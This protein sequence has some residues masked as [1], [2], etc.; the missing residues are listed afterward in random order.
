MITHGESITVLRRS[1]RDKHGDTSL[2]SS[3]QVHGV[4]IFYGD[5]STLLPGANSS[6]VDGRHAVENNVTL[7]CRK[8]SD[9]LASDKIEL[10]D[11]SVLKV[12]GRPQPFSSPLSGWAPGVVVQLREIDG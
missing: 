10:P 3:H 6:Q 7:F 5:S 12:F 2:D 11:G 9:I 8:G 1:G 4:G